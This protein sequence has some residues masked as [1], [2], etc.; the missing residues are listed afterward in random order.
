MKIH[1]QLEMSKENF[2]NMLYNREMKISLSSQ[3]IKYMINQI[4][5]EINQRGLKIENS[6]TNAFLTG[7]R[8]ANI[9]INYWEETWIG[10]INRLI[11]CRS[12]ED[13]YFCISRLFGFKVFKIVKFTVSKI[14]K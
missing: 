8:Y 10:R 2:E 9:T 4:E 11:Q 14:T 6:V 3:N 5:Y 12:K 1:L 7:L 13:F